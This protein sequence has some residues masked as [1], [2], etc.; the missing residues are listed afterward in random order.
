MHALIGTA[1][2]QWLIAAG[3]FYAL[4]SVFIYGKSV[5]LMLN[6]SRDEGGIDT[7]TRALEW[8]TMLAY[9]VCAVSMLGA[10]VTAILDSGSQRNYTS[11]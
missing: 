8:A 5:Y 2:V 4:G 3:L 11:L 1:S 10:L 9:V 7:G 6:S